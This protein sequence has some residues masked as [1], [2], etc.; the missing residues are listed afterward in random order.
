MKTSELIRP[1]DDFG[2]QRSREGIYTLR[3]NRPPLGRSHRSRLLP[4]ARRP[5]RRTVGAAEAIQELLKE[6]TW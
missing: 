1:R 6:R 2:K 3:R 5:H 4:L